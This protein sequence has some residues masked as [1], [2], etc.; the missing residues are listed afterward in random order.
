MFILDQATDVMTREPNMVQVPGPVIGAC[1][2]ILVLA[3][4]PDYAMN[5]N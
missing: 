5:C 1:R 4:H 3:G 2:P